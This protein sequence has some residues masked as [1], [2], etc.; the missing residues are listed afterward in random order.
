M[1]SVGFFRNY[2]DFL[3]AGGIAVRA[4][5]D[6]ICFIMGLSVIFKYRL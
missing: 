2:A 6:V 1:P 3:M 4:D 5:A